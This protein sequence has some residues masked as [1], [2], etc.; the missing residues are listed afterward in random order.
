[1]GEHGRHD[2]LGRAK[3]TLSLPQHVKAKY[4]ISTATAGIEVGVDVG[5]MVRRMFDSV[6]WLEML[7]HYPTATGRPMQ[8]PRRDLIA[9]AAASNEAWGDGFDVIAEGD[10]DATVEDSTYDQAVPFGSHKAQWTPQVS[11]ELLR[12]MPAFEAGLRDDAATGLALLTSLW[13]AAGSG[14]NQGTGVRTALAGDANRKV[15]GADHV[16]SFQ[17]LGRLVRLVPRAYRMLPSCGWMTSD[18]NWITLRHE[19]TDLNGHPLVDKDGRMFNFPVWTAPGFPD[20]GAGADGSLMFGCLACI[21]L[22]EI[23]DM[24]LAQSM[25]PDW[26]QEMITFRFNQSLDCNVVDP[27]GLALFDSAA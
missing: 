15:P 27:R 11:A 4:D 6:S 23:A 17:E 14:V 9:G 19:V 21:G 20:F 2:L 5:P 7:T 26:D 13:V 12:D 22:R 18:T 3:T 25:A 8:I 10:R 1:M 24:R 16:P